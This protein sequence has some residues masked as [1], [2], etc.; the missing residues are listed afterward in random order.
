MWYPSDESLELDL[1]S[2]KL[3]RRNNLANSEVQ[4]VDIHSHAFDVISTRLAPLEEREHM[5][6][7]YHP[8]SYARRIQVDFPRSHTT[9]FLNENQQLESGNT[10][11]YIV[12]DDQAS[13][14]M[15][16]LKNQLVLR[17]KHQYTT[18]TPDFRLVVIPYGVVHI[19]RILNHVEIR[20]ET[21]LLCSVEYHTY[22]IDDVLG[23]L[24]CGSGMKS[25]FYMLYLHAITSHC[26]PDP[27]LH[28]TGTEE[29]LA[30]LGSARSFSFIDLKVEVVEQLQK[31][32]AL[33]PSRQFYPLHL[34]SMQSTHWDPSLPPL[35]QHDK[36]STLVSTIYTH[37]KTLQ[38]F[39]ESTLMDD[40][41]S[42][43]PHH[44][45]VRASDR[46]SRYYH[47]QDAT[48]ITKP[49]LHDSYY[50]NILDGFRA[51]QDTFKSSYR[52]S[53]FSQENMEVI[54][55]FPGSIWD[56]I[57]GWS[58]PRT[59]NAIPKETHQLI[60]TLSYDKLWLV[61]DLLESRWLEIYN[62]CRMTQPAHKRWRYQ[63]A[64]TF[65]AVVYSNPSMEEAA[66]MFMAF[67]ACST[68]RHESTVRLSSTYTLSDGLIPIARSLQDLLRPYRLQLQLTPSC[69]LSQEPS[70]SPQRFSQRTREHWEQETRSA[71]DR[72]VA[73]FIK[74]WPSTNL[75][76]PERNL[77][78]W[79][80]V[81]SSIRQANEYFS[82]CSRNAQLQNHLLALQKIVSQ[83]PAGHVTSSESLEADGTRFYRQLCREATI[84]DRVPTSSHPYSALSIPHLSQI[85][86]S[87]FPTGLLLSSTV[88]RFYVQRQGSARPE[89]RNSIG[90]ESVLTRLEMRPG[91]S[92]VCTSYVEALRESCRTL[93]GSPDMGPVTDEWKN[94]ES[95]VWHEDMCAR[96]NKSLISRIRSATYPHTIHGR[97]LL[98]AGQWPH[99]CIR[100]LLQYLTKSA[101]SLTSFNPGWYRLLL[102]LAERILEHQ[103]A[104]RLLDYSI[105]GKIDEFTNEM[106]NGC[107]DRDEALCEPDWLLVQVSR[108]RFT[109]LN[110]DLMLF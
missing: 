56:R 11:G 17:K 110:I 62:L 107:F 63:V 57:F 43:P 49:S 101:R 94:L 81:P 15:F 33:T 16:G 70:E 68:K 65:S 52:V 42:S 48:H 45:T 82:S 26:L 37:M 4:F 25:W 72:M 14:T 9:F 5:V 32:A 105:L 84:E 1:A 91:L 8:T 87:S 67:I 23:R 54:S 53:R 83:R 88:S 39:Y 80:D 99:I 106:R 108:D 109:L 100:T 97:V 21:K 92:T 60:Q 55:Y 30:G 104:R 77:Q 19:K 47:H 36:F 13:G 79:F 22:V 24:S 75:L 46:G 95:L 51:R 103:R 59:I 6:I 40:S 20:V 96:E 10:R 98:N 78:N 66:R 58:T 34:Q 102:H 73:Y 93:D 28:R 12:D 86:T 50:N 90:L 76:Q 64:F 3:R 7:T 44:L 31:L 2:R 41:D 69:E 29:A 38:C 18:G 35:S 61:N 85:F 27:L 89:S 71:L 74:Q